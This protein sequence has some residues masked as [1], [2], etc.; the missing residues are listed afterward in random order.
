M[1]TLIVNADDFGFTRDV[2]EGI[3]HAHRNGILTAT[4]LMANGGAF[5]HAVRLA[6]ENPTLDVGCHLVLV[7]DG[8]SLVAP[9]RPLPESVSKLAAAI[10]L[11]KM[12]VEAELDAQLRRIVEAGITPLHI[13]AHKHTHLLPP[14]LNAIVNVARRYGVRYIRRPFDLPLGAASP[15]IPFSKRQTSHGLSLMRGRFRRIL[16]A[17]GYLATD[18][19]AGFQVTGRF[20]TAHLAGLLAELP[21]G[22]TE[23][24]THPGFCRDELSAARTRLK[25]SRERELEALCA[26]EVRAA[27]QANAIHLS[28]Y[29]QL[30]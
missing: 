6:Q 16:D 9:Y 19:F 4:T 17:N 18:Y 25:K 30:L 7:G 11:G 3:A 24:M 15:R 20:E 12:D 21:E 22:V 10:Y 2:N 13:D 8:C 1:K 29:R 28:G 23:W 5:D 14:V 26:D 27:L